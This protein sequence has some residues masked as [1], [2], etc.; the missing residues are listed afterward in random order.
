MCETV[1]HAPPGRIVTKRSSPP[2]KRSGL[3]PRSEGAGNLARLLSTE[4]RLEATLRQAREEAVRLVTN[5]R[6]A[7]TTKE[8][9]LVADLEALVRSLETTIGDEQRRKAQELAESA[10]QEIRRFDESGSDRIE[11]LARYVVDRVIGA[12]P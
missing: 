1:G 11:I 7:A 2:S 12:E 9:S 3:P 5:A 8:A 4:E 6:D 10:Q